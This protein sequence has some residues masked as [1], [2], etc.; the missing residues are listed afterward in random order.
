MGVVNSGYLTI[1]WTESVIKFR[2]NYFCTRLREW[3]PNSHFEMN[4]KNT[5]EWWRCGECIFFTKPK[6]ANFIQ[7]M[8]IPLLPW[9]TH[10]NVIITCTINNLKNI[11][12]QI[13]KRLSFFNLILFSFSPFLLRQGG[14]ES[15]PAHWYKN[16]S[17]V[18]ASMKAR[19]M[20]T[21]ILGKEDSK[22]K[23]CENLQVL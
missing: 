6:K 8:L 21:W 22:F 3:T 14:R 4:T 11:K 19:Q 12:N 18:K 16:R 10:I 1:N 15:S 13:F 17:V 9:N 20:I 23:N 7:F 2:A 5:D